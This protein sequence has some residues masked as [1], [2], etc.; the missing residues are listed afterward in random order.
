[1]IATTT[2][3]FFLDFDNI[4]LERKTGYA[5]AQHITILL[6]RSGNVRPENIQ[7]VLSENASAE[8]HGKERVQQES[9]WIELAGCAAHALDLVMKKISTTPDVKNLSA[10]F[11]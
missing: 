9:A 5:L 4:R 11:Q 2:G 10:D 8:T 7:L 6:Q 1:L 3:T